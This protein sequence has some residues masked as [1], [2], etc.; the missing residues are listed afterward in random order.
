MIELEIDG[1]KVTAEPGSMI[2]QV[3]DANGQYIPRFCYHKKLSIAAN[4]RMCLVEVEKVGKP[5][6]A[7]ATPISQGMRVFTNSSK[8]LAAQRAVMEFLLINHPL[9]CPI[10]DQG[11]ECELQ[12]M[13]LGYGDD[14]SRYA[15]Q[16]RAVD[17]EN[18]GSLIATDMTRCIHCTRCVRFGTEVAGMRELGTLWRG[19]HMEIKTFVGKS[20]ASEVSGN[21]IDLCP[22]GALTS[23]PYRYKARAWELQQRH[24]IAPHDCLG[25]N[26]NVHVRRD[27]VMRVVPRANEAVNETWASDRDR[28]SYTALYSEDRLTMP[29]LKLVGRWQ[30][31]SWETALQHVAAELKKTVSLNGA[32]QLAGIISPSATLEEQ[33]LFNQVIRGLGSCNIDHRIRQTDVSDQA[34]MPLFPGFSIDVAELESQKA[35]L[36]LGCDIQHEQPL[37]AIRL[38]KAS[39]QGAKIVAV[40]LTNNSYNF[41]I[42]QQIVCHPLAFIAELAGLVK[43]LAETH[44]KALSPVLAEQLTSS[45]VTE[46]HRQLASALNIQPAAIILGAVAEQH[47]QAATIRFLANTIAEMSGASINLLTCGANT[48]GAWLAGCIPHRGTAGMP[49]TEAGLTA[50]QAFRAQLRAYVLFGLEPEQDCANPAQVTKALEQADFVVAFSAYK[51]DYL[52]QHA[53]VLLPISLFSETSGTFVNVAGQ[54]QSFAAAVPAAEQVK[55]GWKVLRVLAN[56]LDLAG[57]TYTTSIEVRDEL[58]RLVSHHTFTPAPKVEASLNLSVPAPTLMRITEWPMYR[59]DAML[60][61]ALPL[62]QAASHR[63]VGLRI[64]QDLAQKLGLSEGQSAT[65]RQD[66]GQA[67]LTVIIDERVPEG[68]AIIAGGFLETS[69]LAESFGAI[70]INA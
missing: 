56:V 46:Q 37:L 29:M 59:V 19:E 7:C 43:A 62:Q 23:K 64:K 48:A 26:I 65:V 5:V 44:G 24:S 34:A 40:N 49:T 50:D 6:P 15:E 36:L 8:A 54:W 12:D 25:A 10:C 66:Q 57:F 45:T 17:D 42:A 28:F 38:R 16:K 14:I 39:L 11:G 53:D 21:I 2:I 69:Q 70:T 18:L 27:Q 63:P 35:V 60:R 68:C 31:V 22:V 67:N 4:C 61:R 33:Y 58:Q 47:P 3:A 9:D 41:D 1:K 51:S 32:Q 13:A 30:E 52:L 55:P 20:L